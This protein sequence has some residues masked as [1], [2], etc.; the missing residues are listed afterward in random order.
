[1][2]SLAQLPPYTG[3]HIDSEY[4]AN[5][6]KVSGIVCGIATI[7]VGAR[8]VSRK[9]Q[10]LG[11]AADDYTIF[12]ALV[13]FAYEI[14][15]VL[16][17]GIVKM[18]ILLFYRRVFAIEARTRMILYSWMGIVIIWDISFLLCMIL[19]CNP[20]SYFW[21]RVL[22]GPGSCTKHVVPLYA[23]QS[24][25][26]IVT[27]LIIYIFP[28][29]I[30]WKLN[31]STSRKVGLIGVFI[32]GGVVCAMSIVRAATITDILSDDFTYTNVRAAIWASLEQGMMIIT[33]CLPML[34]GMFGKLGRRWLGTKT[35]SSRP[36][37]RDYTS[38]VS[39]KFHRSRRQDTDILNSKYDIELNTTAEGGDRD[40][41]NEYSPKSIHVAVNLH[42][43]DSN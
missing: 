35:I 27:D 4:G 13:L 29:P 8:F 23:V 37:F 25:I 30:I 5:A 33:A 42:Q 16:N 28:M 43:T 1:M 24:A 36:S 34:W 39:E 41:L 15:Y 12:F 31:M 14:I 21:N 19:Q 10:H 26:N 6:V 7:I 11:L 32:A 2:A 22:Q 17:L 40:D 38:S 18:S 9:I 20:T 3:E